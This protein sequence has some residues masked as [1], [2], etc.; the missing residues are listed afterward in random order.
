MSHKKRRIAEHEERAAPDRAAR[1]PASESGPPNE[2]LPVVVEGAAGVGAEPAEVETPV[3]AEGAEPAPPAVALAELRERHLRLQA[4]YDNYRKRVAR[5]R[6]ELQARLRAELARTVL[7]TLDDLGRATAVDPDSASA[8]D[9]I[10]GVELVERKLMQE[11]ERVGLARL[12]VEGEQ[13]DPGEHEAVGTEPAPS[14][15]REWTVAAV[16]QPG[17]R[18]GDI[19]VRPARVR[20]FVAPEPDGAGGDPGGGPQA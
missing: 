6:V 20:V 7:D 18:L 4:E 3:E 10:A 19:L 8:R 13:F 11:L 17:Y 16:L 9:V 12:G 5:E 15:E 2:A 14:A 1:E